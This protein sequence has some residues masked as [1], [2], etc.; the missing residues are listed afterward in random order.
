MSG[1]CLEA[2]CNVSK[3]SRVFECC[4]VS[5]GCK[6]HAYERPNKSEIWQLSGCRLKVIWSVSEWYL[7]RVKCPGKYK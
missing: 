5:R 7:E 4:L 3:S 1:L 2:V 6:E